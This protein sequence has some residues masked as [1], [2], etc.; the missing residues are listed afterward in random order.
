M[1]TRLHRDDCERSR[2]HEG[3]STKIFI[4]CARTVRAKECRAEGK[5]KDAEC[6]KDTLAREYNQV[7]NYID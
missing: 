1:M 2:A 6:F 3:Y 5:V 4:R 7:T